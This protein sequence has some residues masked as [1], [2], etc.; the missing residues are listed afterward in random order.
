MKT[1]PEPRSPCAISTAPLQTK[2]T[3][4]RL[5][6]QLLGLYRD[7]RTLEEEQGVSVLFLALGFLRWYES[8]SS[9]HERHAPLILL[10]VD[11]ERD[12]V[13]GRF[14]LSARDQ[15]MDANLSLRALLESDFG[16]TLPDLPDGADWLPSDYYGL[17]AAAASSRSRWRVLPNAMELSFYSFAKFLMWKDLAPG[18]D[19]D[20]EPGSDVLERLLVGGFES[21]PSI[22]AP[23]ENLDRRFPDPK[24]LGHILDADTSQTQVIAAA[25]S[26]RSMVVQG[27]PGTGKSQTIAN[28]IAGAAMDGKKVLFIAEKR[29][30]LDVV[31]ARLV[32]CG[33]GPLCLE[34]HSHKANRR[35]GLRGTQAHARPR[36]AAGRERGAVRARPPGAGRP[37]PHFG[38]AAR[39]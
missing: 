5:Q 7:A 32:K 24:D 33:I 16:L 21:G 25:R 29:A 19:Q 9:D 30:A 36:P 17:V 20:G 4:D 18:A 38:P 31:H 8:E 22:F 13:R 11:L 6:K 27:P 28:V 15:D 37:E 23:D 12:S 39:G 10:P 35:H 26:G 3:R 1:A 14:R 34:L 2:L